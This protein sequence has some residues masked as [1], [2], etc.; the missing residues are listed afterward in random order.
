MSSNLYPIISSACHSSRITDAQRLRTY[1]ARRASLKSIA[2]QGHQFQRRVTEGR[3]G[4]RNQKTLPLLL[5]RSKQIDAISQRR[6][7]PRPRPSFFLICAALPNFPSFA[8]LLKGISRTFCVC[9]ARP[10][11][12]KSSLTSCPPRREF[13]LIPPP[14]PPPHPPPIPPCHNSYPLNGNIHKHVRPTP[15]AY[16]R[17]APIYKERKP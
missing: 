11:L 16:H 6:S 2:G 12:Y 7:R 9:S 15:K 17:C 1:R 4:G 13:A 14:S 10:R 5:A 3:K 8:N